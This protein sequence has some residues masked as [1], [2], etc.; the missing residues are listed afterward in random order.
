MAKAKSAVKKSPKAEAPRMSL[1]DAMAALEQAGSA[2][3][4]KTYAR[5]GADGPMFGVSFAALKELTKRIGVDHELAL[6][7]W[8]TGNLDARNLAVKVVDP[9]RMGSAE[10]DRWA[11]EDSASRACGWYV[12]MVAGEGPH[13]SKKVDRWL[14]AKDERVRCSGWSL[15]GHLA[16]R[17]ERVP[18]A[19]FEKLLVAIERGIDGAP[20][21]ERA[22][23]NAALIAIGC[24]SAAL[25][26]AATAAAKR[27]GQ[28]E[29]DHGDTACK[30]PDAARTIETAW[31]YAS[32]KGHA[33]PAALER[34]R[35]TPRRR[36]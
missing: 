31:A 16:Q 19:V 25:R 23:M 28:V 10:L 36:C 27:I 32:S 35:E 6:A 7:L 34:T 26:R 24:R 3:T 20:N 4:R 13:A 30:T 29:V 21:L 12:G 33:S 2:Q 8:D 9:A 17:D 14:A 11:R 15:V 18:D 5:H 22:R 1:E